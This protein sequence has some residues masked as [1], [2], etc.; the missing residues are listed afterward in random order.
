MA[1]GPFLDFD[2][3][4]VDEVKGLREQTRRNKKML[5]E[6]SAALNRLDGMLREEAKG[7]SMQSLYRKVPDMLKGYVELTYDLNNHPNYRLIES[8]LYASEYY[9]LSAQSFM[10]SLTQGDKRSF[11]LST[12]R[13][14]DDTSFHWHI[15]FSHE[16]VDRFFQLEKSPEPWHIIKE[17][18]GDCGSKE[19]LLRSFFTPQGPHC[20]KPDCGGKARWRYFGHACVL[21]ESGS[22]SL[23][24][25]PSA[26]YAYAS[27]T[28]RHTY[29]DLPDRIDYVLITHNHQDHVLL[30]TLI[31]LRKRIGQIIIPK[32]ARGGLQDPS[33]KLILRAIGFRNIVELDEMETIH[34]ATGSI[35][36]LP[37]LGE[38]ADLNI[39][40]KMA[41]LVRINEHAML[42]AADSCAHEPKLYEHIRKEAGRVDTLFVGMECDGA[43]LSWL[44]GPLMS[45]RPEREMDQSRRLNGSDCEQ[46]M[47]M[48]ARLD[49]QRVYVYAMGQEPWLGHVMGF[50]YTADSRPLVESDRLIGLCRERSIQAERLFMSHEEYFS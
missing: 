31:K 25:D 10:L 6:L 22:T 13:L 50:K 32:N 14:E 35:T 47:E 38:H 34:F 9:D 44:Y 23:L 39:Q 30:E 20:R 3:K 15:P 12:P 37:F 17:M 29:G 16:N 1:G 18:F 27:D 4:R 46:A 26:S 11:V 42:F 24:L 41:Y 49:C 36:G 33:L 28:Q 48:I 43:P 40:S 7:L 45:R 19:D 2:G 21:I 8:L 5:I